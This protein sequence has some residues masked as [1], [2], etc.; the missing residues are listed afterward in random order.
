MCYTVAMRTRVECSCG[1]QRELS[2]FYAGKRIR[3]ADCGCVLEVP[4]VSAGLYS[5]RRIETELNRPAPR[6]GVWLP[7][8]HRPCAHVPRP[9]GEVPAARW[10]GG[11]SLFLVLVAVIIALNIGRILQDG[12]ELEEHTPPAPTEQTETTPQVPGN[13]ADPSSDRDIERE[14]EF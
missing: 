5:S 13:S 7:L 2:E 9:A 11:N 12:R 6:K 4:G 1:W 8:T 14:D 10:Q 3:C